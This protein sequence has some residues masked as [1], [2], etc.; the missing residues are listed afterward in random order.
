MENNFTPRVMINVEDDESPNAV[1]LTASYSEYISLLSKGWVPVTFK[2]MVYQEYPGSS[3]VKISAGTADAQ[4]NNPFLAKPDAQSLQWLAESQ[5]LMEL[6]NKFRQLVGGVGFAGWK[7][8]GKATVC[9]LTLVIYTKVDGEYTL[10]E[11]AHWVEIDLEA[12]DLTDCLAIYE[13]EE[14]GYPPELELYK[15][16]AVD[17]YPVLLAARHLLVQHNL[18]K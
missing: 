17:R 1:S 12:T 13:E 7:K 5:T 6:E 15:V 11:K 18:S 10:P 8:T 14:G 9:R 3:K 16:I 2:K 4:P